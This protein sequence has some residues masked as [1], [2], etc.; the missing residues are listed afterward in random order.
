MSPALHTEKALGPA[1]WG[2][3]HMA[4]AI[5]EELERRARKGKP[6]KLQV[7]AP[8]SDLGT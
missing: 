2:V 1:K 4:E 7:W 3:E 8:S 5:K 6:E